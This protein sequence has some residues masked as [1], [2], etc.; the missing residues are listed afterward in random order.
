MLRGRLET[1]RDERGER[2]ESLPLRYTRTHVR[3]ENQGKLRV[4]CT[5]LHV[6]HSKRDKGTAWITTA[7]FVFF[8]VER[9]DRH[10]YVFRQECFPYAE[11]CLLY[12]VPHLCRVPHPVLFVKSRER[13]ER[14]KAGGTSISSHAYLDLRVYSSF[15]LTEPKSLARSI[16]AT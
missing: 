3:V 2:R 14:T 13:K 6:A 5:S 4:K 16:L 1:E 12:G 10:V 11:V 8:Y 7:V 9:P 15:N